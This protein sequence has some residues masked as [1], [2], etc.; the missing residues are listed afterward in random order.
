VLAA[1]LAELGDGRAAL[2]CLTPKGATA[3]DTSALDDAGRLI[4]GRTLLKG[5]DGQQRQGEALLV[6]LARRSPSSPQAEEAVRLLTQQ[7]GKA[8]LAALAALPP[9]WRDRAP[10]QARLALESG[11]GRQV[12]EVLRRW[13]DDP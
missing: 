11:D 7:E 13:P 5:D 2:A 6:D 10:V 1:G 9:S 3:A 4:L 12:A 8:G